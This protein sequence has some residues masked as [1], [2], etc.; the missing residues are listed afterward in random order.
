MSMAAPGTLAGEIAEIPALVAALHQQ[1]AALRETA[2][3]IRAFKPRLLVTIGRGS[4]DAV[5]E[6]LGR[7]AAIQL[8]LLPASLPPALVTLNRAPLQF[9]GALVLAVSQSGSSPDLVESVAA[10]RRG[11]ALTIAITNALESALAAACAHVIPVGAGTERSIAATKSVVLSLLQGLA[12]MAETAAPG[13]AAK[14]LD[15]MP[16][17]L[18]HALATDWRSAVESLAAPALFVVARGIAY[19]VAREAAL[20]L[21]ELCGQFAEAISGAEIMHGPKAAL[22]PDTPI[23]AFVPDD[24]AAASMQET[25]AGLATVSRR[26]VC[27]GQGPAGVQAIALPAPAAPFLAPVLHLAAFYPLAI[28]IAQARGRS[29]DDPAHIQKVTLTR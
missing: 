21:K 22:Q 23:L 2:A 20:K 5:C 9:Q 8:G 6:I 28:A 13:G 16:D 17:A 11:G 1:T 19:G 26:I 24:E 18:S 12:L 14:T 27:L 10:A 25:L 15:G 3:A 7:V 29:P 4:S